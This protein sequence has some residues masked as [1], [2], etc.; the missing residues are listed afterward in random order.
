MRNC[1]NFGDFGMYS[2]YTLIVNVFSR[3]RLPMNLRKMKPFIHGDL[4]KISVLVIS[5]ILLSALDVIAIAL[6]GLLTTLTVSGIQSNKPDTRIEILLEKLQIAALDFRTQVALI[7]AA[8]AF[9]LLSRTL[10]SIFVLHK[11]INNLIIAAPKEIVNA[12]KEAARTKESN[13]T[14]Y[15]QIYCT[16]RNH[17]RSRGC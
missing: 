11:S 1:V 15:Q 17:Q 14:L 9:L 6:V 3:R 7:G 10:I 12:V 4:G 5:N 13:S 8:A 16:D 2:V